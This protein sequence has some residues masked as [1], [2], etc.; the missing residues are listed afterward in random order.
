MLNEIQYTE[1]RSY[2]LTKK[3]PIDILMEIND[4]FI[5]QISDLQREEYLSFEDAFEKTKLSWKSELR[6]YWDGGYD[7]NDRTD[8][9]RKTVKQQMQSVLYPALKISILGFLTIVISAVIMPFDY[10]MY[11]FSAFL[12]VVIFSPIMYGLMHYKDFK[13]VKKYNNYVLT[14]LQSYLSSGYVFGGV[15]VQMFLRYKEISTEFYELFN[16]FILDFGAVVM[17]VILFAMLM[18]SVFGLLSQRIYIRQIQK[19]KPFLKYL[20]PSK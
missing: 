9:Q 13:L 2:L 16:L 3:L 4:H 5:S 6:L 1:I 7:L 14:H 8:L 20:K 18:L 17:F 15:G 19:I 11:S 10:F 12:I